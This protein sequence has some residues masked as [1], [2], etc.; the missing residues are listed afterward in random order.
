MIRTND[1]EI[2]KAV[3][4]EFMIQKELDHPNIVKVY[5]MYFNPI[6]SRIQII[7]EQIEGAELFD[8]ICKEGPFSGIDSISSPCFYRS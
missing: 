7:M 5:E 3:K 6:S 1:I 4:G 8:K 2:L